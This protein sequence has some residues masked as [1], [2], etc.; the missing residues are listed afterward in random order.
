MSNSNADTLKT[1]TD[2]IA[3]LQQEL[4]DSKREIVDLRLR[5]LE[6]THELLEKD[7]R[8]AQLLGHIE[9]LEREKWSFQSELENLRGY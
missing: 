7:Q 5:D 1:L 8:I 3:R 9:D 2:K 6:N 4:L